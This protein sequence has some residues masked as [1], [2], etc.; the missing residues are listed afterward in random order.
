LV[1]IEN[2]D[3]FGFEGG[4]QVAESFFEETGQEKKGGTS[5]ESLR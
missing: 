3:V 4:A 1:R 2:F 5:V